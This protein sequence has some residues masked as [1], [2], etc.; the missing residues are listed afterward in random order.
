MYVCI[1]LYE[2]CTKDIMKVEYE[3]IEGGK[4]R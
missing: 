1:A 2:Y 4:R 3:N